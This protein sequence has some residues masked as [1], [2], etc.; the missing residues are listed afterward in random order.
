MAEVGERVGE[1]LDGL[2]FSHLIHKSSIKQINPYSP[3]LL[4]PEAFNLL[5]SGCSWVID[6]Q[7]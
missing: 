7:S 2:L 3:P 4:I 1:P 5:P 6:S